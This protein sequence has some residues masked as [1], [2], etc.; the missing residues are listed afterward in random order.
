MYDGDEWRTLCTAPCRAR[1]SVRAKYRV[2]GNGVTPSKPFFVDPD[3]DPI[4]LL[5]TEGSVYARDAGAVAV[6]IG[7]VTLAVGF[8]SLT[9]LFCT[10]A[11]KTRANAIMGIGATTVALG[12]VL[13]LGNETHLRFSTRSAGVVPEVALGHGLTLSPEGIKF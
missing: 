7:A 1:V 5:V 6:P 2:A 8:L 11:Q 9:C 10:D 3:P 4:T 13:L 12:F